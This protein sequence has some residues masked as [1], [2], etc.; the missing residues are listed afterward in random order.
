MV[1]PPDSQASTFSTIDMQPLLTK[2][3]IFLI[4][5]LLGLVAS[6]LQITRNILTTSLTC[7]CNK[8]GEPFVC[9]LDVPNLN[10]TT[11][12][13]T[14]TCDSHTDTRFSPKK[15]AETRFLLDLLYNH[16]PECKPRKFRLSTGGKKKSRL[17][18]TA[19]DW[20]WDAI[21]QRSEALLILKERTWIGSGRVLGVIYLNGQGQ[22]H[23]RQLSWKDAS[24]GIAKILHK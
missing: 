12:C 20:R 23:L 1:K 6:H 4:R 11:D 13:C 3:N 9:R 16:Y 24:F 10:Q 5:D 22:F 21:G 18:S 17:M 2:G 19:Y 7:E 15:L 8:Q 14:G